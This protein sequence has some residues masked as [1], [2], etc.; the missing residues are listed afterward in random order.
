MEPIEAI[1]GELMGPQDQMLYY[2]KWEGKDSNGEDWPKEW[3]TEKK[4]GKPGLK[5]WKVSDKRDA[6]RSILSACVAQQS[7]LEDPQ[8]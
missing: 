5:D 1:L 3:I 2:V 4:M 7:V 8:D 6:M